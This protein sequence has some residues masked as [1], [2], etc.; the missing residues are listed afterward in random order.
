MSI[1]KWY[2]YKTNHQ[3]VD[4]LLML[5]TIINLAI[6]LNFTGG[7]NKWVVDITCYKPVK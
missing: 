7:L 6:L 2:N 4:Y 3:S 1:L 5:K